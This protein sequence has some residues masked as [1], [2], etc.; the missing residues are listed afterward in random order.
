MAQSTKQHRTYRQEQLAEVQ[1]LLRQLPEKDTRKTKQEAV[2]FLKDDFGSALKKGY[3]PKELAAYLKDKNQPVSIRLIEEALRQ[4][5]PEQST[6][7]AKHP[8]T[9][10]KPV[11]KQK[12]QIA[13][14]NAETTTRGGFEIIPDRPDGEL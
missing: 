6:T 2:E 5:P 3:S 14:T 12:P 13:Q 1:R 8:S 10:V 11:L 7:N 4:K 9:E